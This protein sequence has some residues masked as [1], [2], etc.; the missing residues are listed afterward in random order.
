MSVSASVFAPSVSLNPCV[1]ASACLRVSV[2]LCLCASA[3][4]RLC[5]SVSLSRS[6][7]VSVPRRLAS[8]HAHACVHERVRTCERACA[9]FCI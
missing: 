1:F 6:Q 5:V 8:V 9:Y 7:N 3:T 4:L 2:D